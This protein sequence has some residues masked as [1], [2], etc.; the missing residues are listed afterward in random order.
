MRNGREYFHSI[1]QQIIDL[2]DKAHLGNDER[3]TIE[4]LDFGKIIFHSLSR[5]NLNSLRNSII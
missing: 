5:V 1:H 3:I 4:K 2:L